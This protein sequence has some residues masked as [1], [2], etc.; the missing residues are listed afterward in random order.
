MA[1]AFSPD[2]FG[3]LQDSTA[4]QVLLYLARVL[5]APSLEISSALNIV[6]FE[7]E[8]ALKKLEAAKLV[9]VHGDPITSIYSPTAAGLQLKRQISTLKMKM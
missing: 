8:D 4:R 7:V 5:A 2:V 9:K 1:E 6:P 3:I